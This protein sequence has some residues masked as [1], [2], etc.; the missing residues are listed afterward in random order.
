MEGLSEFIQEVSS[1]LEEVGMTITTAK[2][3][4]GSGKIWYAL[5]S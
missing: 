5:V 1:I 2:E 4:T 3:E